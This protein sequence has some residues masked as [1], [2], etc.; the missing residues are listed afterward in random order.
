MLGEVRP[1]PHPLVVVDRE[2]VIDMQEQEID[3][4]QLTLTQM[5]KARTIDLSKEDVAEL[6][7]SQL[8]P[9]RKSFSMPPP[10]Q[11]KRMPDLPK[12]SSVY[13]PDTKT[14]GL[15]CGGF[16]PVKVPRTEL[17]GYAPQEAPPPAASKTA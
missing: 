15:Y 3:P 14:V 7:G 17:V 9:P 10:P 16:K 5:D 11:R 8:P 4:Y 13:D 1:Q 2:S 6:L 12:T